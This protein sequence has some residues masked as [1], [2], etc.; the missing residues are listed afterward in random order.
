MKRFRSDLSHLNGDVLKYESF[1]I[2]M[3]IFLAKIVLIE[4]NFSMLHRSIAFTNES[5]KGGC[6]PSGKLSSFRSVLEA[7]FKGRCI[8]FE[9][10]YDIFQIGVISVIGRLSN[11]TGHSE[12]H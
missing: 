10:L 9:E 8:E 1:N 12:C 7:H 6:R 4:Q 2:E 5:L 11:G 3:L